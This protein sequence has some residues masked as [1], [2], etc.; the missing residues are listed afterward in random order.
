MNKRIKVFQSEQYDADFPSY[1]LVK[2]ISEIQRHLDSIPEAF[3]N[4]AAIEIGNT[5]CGSYYAQ[6]EIT[7]T[8]PETAEEE[9]YRLGATAARARF[10]EERERAT[11]RQLQAKY[12]AV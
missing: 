4:E 5:S 7:Y 2:F 11:L 9:A 6:I 12:G 1:N 3:R 8:R 10:I